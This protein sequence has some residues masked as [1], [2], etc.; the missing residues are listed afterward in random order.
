MGKDGTVRP[1]D[2]IPTLS[3]GAEITA[4]GLRE[5]SRTKERT[6]IKNPNSALPEL[7]L[8]NGNRKWGGGQ[9]IIAII[10]KSSPSP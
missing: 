5:L 1:G 4:K 3:Q 7:H 10:L 8:G 2:R 6:P 9:G